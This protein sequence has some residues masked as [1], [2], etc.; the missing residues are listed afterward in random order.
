MLS[1]VR[2]AWAFIRENDARAIAAYVHSRDAH[3]L[4]QF[5][6]YGLCG[7]AAVI[8]HNLVA[9]WIGLTVF[10]FTGE[11]AAEL[12][13]DQ[14][15]NNQVIANLLAF[16]VGNVVAYS[17]NALWVFHGGRHS[18]RREF[19]FFTGIA[20]FS[21]I[22]GLFAGPIL[23]TRLDFNEHLAQISLIVTSALVN[24]ICRKF[25]VFKA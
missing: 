15:S 20:F 3:P 1:L 10:P 22:V 24:Y 17:T 19:L 25:L 7:V 16:P 21:F 11:G 23:I 8:A 6:K 9:Y 2:D 4:V 5:A 18:R 12:S 13:A 14:K